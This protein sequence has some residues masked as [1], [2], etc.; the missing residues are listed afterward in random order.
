MLLIYVFQRPTSCL[1]G[2]CMFLFL[3]KLGRWRQKRKCFVE[4]ARLIILLGLFWACKICR[5]AVDCFCQG[6]GRGK[7]LLGPWGVGI[8]CLA[9]AVCCFSGGRNIVVVGFVALVCLFYVGLAHFFAIVDWAFEAPEPARRLLVPVRAT[10]G[11]SQVGEA[12]RSEMQ[13]EWRRWIQ[14]DEPSSRSL[15]VHRTVDPR[16]ASLSPNVD[17]SKAAASTVIEGGLFKRTQFSQGGAPHGARQPQSPRGSNAQTP[18]I[19]R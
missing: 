11:C 6:G 12:G 15:D 2:F 9:F 16:E 13:I 14:R 17:T 5:L 18:T 4:L 7:H 8:V 10:S 3:L 1:L 19:I